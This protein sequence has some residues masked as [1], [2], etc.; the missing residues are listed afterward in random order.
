MKILKEL[1]ITT[2]NGRYNRPRNCCEVECPICGTPFTV[3]KDH[4]KTISSCKSCVAAINSAKA[5]AAANTK[6]D[7]GKQVCTNC[8]TEKLLTEYHKD[9]SKASGY[10]GVCKDCR[11]TLEKE[12][13][14]LYRK[15]EAG[16]IA[17]ANKKGRRM[18]RIKSTCDNTI[19]TDNLK[20]LKEA[21]D[22]KCAY[23]GIKLDF[24]VP[25]NVHLDHV[26]PLSKDGA[27][28]IE[29]VVWSCASCNLS[30]SD[31][32]IDQ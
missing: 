17:N 1:G 15:S 3:R 12:G 16:K 14:K 24:T 31:K 23:C 21:Q 11:Y 5:T 9:S 32:I 18:S 4:L 6:L 26:I 28:T 19:T 7:E 13:N 22:N 27:H 30:K 10:R 20:T 29:N 8:N 25:R 2:L